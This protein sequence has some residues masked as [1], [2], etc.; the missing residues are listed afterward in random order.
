MG[1]QRPLIDRNIEAW[2]PQ[3]LLLQITTSRTAY[4]CILQAINKLPLVKQVFL[5]R[6]KQAYILKLTTEFRL[7]NTW[8]Q[9]HPFQGQN[10]W[11]IAFFQQRNLHIGCIL[12][13]MLP[14]WHSRLAPRVRLIDNGKS[15]AS[16]MIHRVSQA[17]PVRHPSVLDISCR[18]LVQKRSLGVAYLGEIES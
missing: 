15:P 7:V 5:T 16:E 6:V 9:K 13:E 2:F 10:T 8:G 14:V 11:P 3:I 17:S 4:T 18:D 1:Y 12:H